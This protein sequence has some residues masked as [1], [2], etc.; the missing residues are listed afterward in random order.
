M[1]MPHDTRLSHPDPGGGLPRVCNATA[2][3]Y[4]CTRQ[5]AY[6]GAQ[7]WRHPGQAPSA[8]RQAKEHRMMHMFIANN[9]TELLA[10]CKAKVARRPHRQAT[11]AQLSNGVPL[12]LQQLMHTLQAEEGGDDAGSLRISGA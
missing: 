7:S 9:R 11:E 10:R 5:Q 12:F 6:A 2:L 1:R 3:S 8:K 4:A